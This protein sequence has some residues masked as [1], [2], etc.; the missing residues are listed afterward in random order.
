[1][2]HLNIRL[3]YLPC[4]MRLRPYWQMQNSMSFIY[5]ATF[6]RNTK[7]L[8]FHIFLLSLFLL[9]GIHSCI[10]DNKGIFSES[11]TWRWQESRE[12]LRRKK[13]EGEHSRLSASLRQ[14]SF[15]FRLVLTHNK[16]FNQQKVLR[17]Y[18]VPGP[19]LET[20]GTMRSKDRHIL[21]RPLSRF[22]S[23]VET[24]HVTTIP[25]WR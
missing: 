22:L 20:R 15:C 24:N 21:K 12:R 5:K 14:A 6:L 13:L 25:K 8:D 16:H 3:L 1:M 10:T 18:Q 23:E 9:E 11:F 4:S 17:T 2:S 19:M 7:L